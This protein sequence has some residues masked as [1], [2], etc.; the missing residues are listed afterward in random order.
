M[1]GEK[2]GVIVC[3][4]IINTV[5]D[6]VDFLCK[7]HRELEDDGIVIINFHNYDSEKSQKENRKWEGVGVGEK[8][9]MFGD[10]AFLNIINQNG[11]EVVEE[12]CKDVIEVEDIK[13]Y[14]CK[15]VG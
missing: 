13:F 3:N 10:D 7:V 1:Y 15:K 4:D 6:P 11:F 8:V 9:T 5:S 12:Y 14:I 2:F